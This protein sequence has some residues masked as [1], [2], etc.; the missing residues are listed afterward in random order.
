MKIIKLIILSLAILSPSFTNGQSITQIGQNYYT[1][2]IPSEEFEFFSAAQSTGRQRQANWCWAACVQMVLNYH[3]L[4]ITQEQVV[5]KIYGGLVDQPAGEQQIMYALSGW[6]PNVDG[7]VSQ[8][9]CQLGLNSANEITSNLA[10]KWPLIVGLSN[11]QGGNGHAFVLT[12]IYYTTDM[13]NNTIP[14]K[15]VLRDPWPGNI[16]RQEMDWYEF[17]SRLM[18]AF[19]VWVS[20]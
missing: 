7:G 16:S 6:A 20:R 18:V 15:V 19:K 4:H 13:Y 2:G 3:G 12:A 14:Y 5:E 17:S 11:P 10:Y 8:I 9:Y 1:A